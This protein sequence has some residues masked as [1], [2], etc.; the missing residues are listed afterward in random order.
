MKNNF[1]VILAF[2]MFIAIV[3]AAPAPHQF[4]VNNKTRECGQFWGGDEFTV[5]ELPEGWHDYKEGFY[6][7]DVEDSILPYNEDFAREVCNNGSY[8][9]NPE[10]PPYSENY[11]PITIETRYLK[12]LNPTH[13]IGVYSFGNVF[14]MVNNETGECGE[15]KKN[16][17]Y[18][19]LSMHESSL[20]INN[21]VWSSLYE[22]YSEV[23]ASM[24]CKQIGY[25]Y[26]GFVEPSSIRS[27]GLTQRQL[28]SDFISSVIFLLILAFIFVYIY[29]KIKKS[30]KKNLP[31]MCP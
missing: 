5:L 26:I 9:Q 20:H 12:N 17:S 6:I 19:N 28:A 18:E 16:E 15:L 31:N 11:E 13:K 24:F 3:N 29:I 25:E 27:T 22:H 10:W 8:T 2:F 30:S 4:V 23:A 14:L 1:A 21:K 7:Y